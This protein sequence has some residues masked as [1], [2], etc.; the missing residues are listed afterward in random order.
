MLAWKCDLVGRQAL[1]LRGATAN[2]VP[3]RHC[4]VKPYNCC[5]SWMYPTSGRGMAFCANLL[6]QLD[7]AS[8]ELGNHSPA[9][10]NSYS[11]AACNSMLRME[12]LGVEEGT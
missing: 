5:R 12:G 4:S 10:L 2:A 1:Q 7:W 8:H 3:G 9:E 6:L 11:R